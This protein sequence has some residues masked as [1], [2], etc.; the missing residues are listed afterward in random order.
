MQSLQQRLLRCMIHIYSVI[1]VSTLLLA[2]LMPLL[3][4]LR[5]VRMGYLSHSHI[6]DALIAHVA[7]V[8]PRRLGFLALLAVATPHASSSPPVPAP[9]RRNKPPVAACAR[10][11]PGGFS[12]AIASIASHVYP[13]H[14]RPV[15]NERSAIQIAPFESSRFLY[16][17]VGYRLVNHW[18]EQRRATTTRAR[19]VLLPNSTWHRMPRHVW[20]RW[21]RH[22]M[23][24]I[25]QVCIMGWAMMD[26]TERDRP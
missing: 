18:P 10:S 23:R 14:R 11:V 8:R 26:V 16:H 25:Y 2:L 1:T 17:A 21:T 13:Q 5:V 7:V 19:V 3:L 6:D 15:R 9:R 22:H 12:I 20:H 24:K 4:P